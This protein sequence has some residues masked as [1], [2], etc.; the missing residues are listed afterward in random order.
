MNRREHS[1][2]RR[3]FRVLLGFVIAV[4]L[5]IAPQMAQA[6]FTSKGSAQQS[7]GTFQLTAPASVTGTYRCP[8]ASDKTGIVKIT[9]FGAVPRASSY[10]LTLN[11]GGGNIAS[12]TVANRSA[13]LHI[14]EKP[15]KGT[16]TLT[17]RADLGNW[18]GPNLTRTFQCKGPPGD[19]KFSPL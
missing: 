5:V 3:P 12:E 4:L 9:D 15:K 13:T 11:S 18:S 6:T 8:R 19:N 14:D 7:I 17:I 1:D 16:W 2:R 10:L